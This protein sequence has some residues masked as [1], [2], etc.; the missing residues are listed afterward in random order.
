MQAGL[1]VNQQAGKLVYQYTCLLA[2]PQKYWLQHNHSLYNKPD[3]TKAQKKAL[4]AW[5][6][7][8]PEW[9]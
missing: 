8:K 3:H 5:L 4:Q 9:N 6:G 2:N 1:S 7:V